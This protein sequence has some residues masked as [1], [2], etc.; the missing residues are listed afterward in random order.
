M[1]LSFLVIYYNQEAFVRRSLDSILTQNIP[2]EYE[3]LVGDDGSS[4]GTRA[5][6]QEY[7]DKYPDK[8]RMY[9]MPRDADG[10][11]LEF[12]SARNRLNIL[13]HAKGEYICF[14]DGDDYY[15]SENF[16]KDGIEILDRDPSII[17][18]ASRTDWIYPDGKVETYKGHLLKEGLVPVTTYIRRYFFHASSVVFR[19]VFDEKQIQKLE[20]MHG[21]FS[22]CR[23][24]MYIIPMGK[25]YFTNQPGFMYWQNM[26]GLFRTRSR[27]PMA[28]A[29]MEFND[30]VF[31]RALYRER[32]YRNA[33]LNALFFRYRNYIVSVYCNRKKM[34]EVLG[35]EQYA[36]MLRMYQGTETEVFLTWKQQPLSKKLKVKW[37]YWSNILW[38]SLTT[39]FLLGKVR[40]K[41]E[42]VLGRN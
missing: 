40:R 32:A 6:V 42:K 3:I 29:L 2:Y 25:L 38:L 30:C 35:E 37:W 27:D 4:D 10:E 16:A 24:T 34:A 12:R 41:I 36:R 28:V 21:D 19:N 8:I 31:L 5:I 7:I 15:G 20:D 1:K 18:C 13:R 39:R 33:L 26:N 23:I 14:L 9:V 11:F 17:A 22:D